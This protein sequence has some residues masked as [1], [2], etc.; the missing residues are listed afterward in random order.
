MNFH[1]CNMTIHNWM[2]CYNLTWELDDDDPLEINIPE[3]KGIYTLEGVFISTDQFLKPL[4]IKKVNIGLV[5]NL[6]FSN[7]GDYSDEEAMG[8]ITDLLHE[9]QYLFPTNFSE[10]KGIVGN[11]GELKIPLRFDEKPV[12]QWSYRLNSCYK[13]KFKYELKWML[14]EGVIEPQVHSKR[15]AAM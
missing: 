15:E 7:I 1:Q 9:F 6:K 10:M 2:E 3:S 14:E 5:E 12:K 8:N 11:I 13:E 4:K